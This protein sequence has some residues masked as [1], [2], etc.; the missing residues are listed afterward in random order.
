MFR[1]RMR[2][3][4][5]STVSLDD[6]PRE[7]FASLPRDDPFDDEMSEDPDDDDDASDDLNGDDDTDVPI[8]AWLPEM[9]TCLLPP[10]R[11]PVIWTAPPSS[12]FRTLRRLRC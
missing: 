10:A 9:V 7:Y 2:L 4:G 11:A 5:D 12:P 1:S 8:I 6:R 3:P